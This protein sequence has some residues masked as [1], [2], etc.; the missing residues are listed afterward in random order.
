MCWLHELIR[1]SPPSLRP[2]QVLE[3]PSAS[4]EPA[5][6]DKE[7]QE[8]AMAIEFSHPGIVK[9]FAYAARLKKAKADNRIQVPS[10]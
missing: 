6:A 9:T 1:Y 8:A 7:M 4:L 2:L 10:L 5:A 3:W